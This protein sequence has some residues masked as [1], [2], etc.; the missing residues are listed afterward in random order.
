MI[1]MELDSTLAMISNTFSAPNECCEYTAMI[2]SRRMNIP[3]A[4]S[5]VHFREDAVSLFPD[6]IFGKSCDIPTTHHPR[7][8]VVTVVDTACTAYGE[9]MSISSM[10]A[11]TVP[12][13]YPRM[14]DMM[15]TAAVNSIL[16]FFRKQTSST[17]VIVSSVSRSSSSMPARRQL[18]ATTACRSANEWMI[19]MGFMLEKDA[20]C[21]HFDAEGSN[22]ISKKRQFIG[23]FSQFV[24]RNS[25]LLYIIVTFANLYTPITYNQNIK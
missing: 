13:R 15:M 24:T 22:F 12:N 2:T 4:A 1:P 10:E 18:N 21:L 7:I 19:H 17:M 20:I 6:C 8:S 25:H 23:F 16:R 14:F 3:P 9:L 5:N 11:P